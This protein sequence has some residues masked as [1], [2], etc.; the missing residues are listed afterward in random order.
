MNNKKSTV[1]VVFLCM[2]FLVL[3]TILGIIVYERIIN[4]EK[5]AEPIK[6]EEP[7]ETVLTTEE[8]LT[9]LS[10]EWGTC[11]EGDGCYGL[12]ISKKDDG[13]YYFTPYIMWSEGRPGGT[14]TKTEKNE[15]NVYTVTVHYDAYDSVESSGPESTVEYKINISDVSSNTIYVNEAKYQ[16]ITGDRETF[17][18]SIK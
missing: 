15:E 13:T 9:T 2:I 7:Q 11:K 12:I 14:V 18:N 6:V 10:G 5:P 8:L 1:I 4:K 17:F 16:K 3:G